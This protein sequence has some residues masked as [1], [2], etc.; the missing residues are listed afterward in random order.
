MNAVEY[1][2]DPLES[3][4]RIIGERFPETLWALLSGSVLTHH[5]TSG[6]DLDIVVVLPDDDPR[7]PCRDSLDT[8]GWP[9]E[10]FLHDQRTLAEHIGRARPRRQ[11]DLVRMIASGVFITGQHDDSA[12]K[13]QVECAAILAAGPLPLTESERRGV[14][15]RLTDLLDD[16]THATDPGER[17]VLAATAWI[18]VA[19]K[20]L[21][22]GSRWPGD[23]KWLLRELRDYDPDIANRWLAAHGNCTAIRDLLQEILDQ[24]GGALFAGHRVTGSRSTRLPIEDRPNDG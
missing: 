11:P 24:A 3:A 10:M 12:L 22:P 7:V 19:D 18:S 21:M 14:R 13:L 20:A 4:R 8:H 9:V 15:Y 2:R 17:T 6:S 1:P 23:G 16:L 5:R